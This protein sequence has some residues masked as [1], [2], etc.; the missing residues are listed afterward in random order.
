VLDTRS[1][2]SFTN[3]E[4]LQ[5][6]ISGSVAIKVSRVSGANAVVSGLFFD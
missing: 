6:A 4:Y 3:G 5:W 1:V 2:S